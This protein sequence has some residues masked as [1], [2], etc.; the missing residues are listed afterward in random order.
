M[1]YQKIIDIIGGVAIGISSDAA[2]SHVDDSLTDRFLPGRT[3]DSSM[4]KSTRW[5]VH[6]E[7]RDTSVKRTS[8]GDV[9][10]EGSW[11]KNQHGDLPHLCGAFA[12]EQWEQAGL[13]TMHAVAVQKDGKTTL[14][15]GPSGCGK[16]SVALAA[17]QMGATVL[18]SNTSLLDINAKGIYLLAGTKTITVREKDREQW[19]L[20]E[21]ATGGWIHVNDMV[22]EVNGEVR[23]DAIILADATKPPLKKQV[24]FPDSFH[25]I[26]AQVG[27]PLHQHCV[28]NGGRGMF[29][30]RT[31]MENRQ[32]MVKNLAREMRVIPLWTMHGHS[33][34][35]AH[36]IG[37]L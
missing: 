3:G 24:P 13:W 27:D 37:E 5:I 35:I 31:H 10:I 22:S 19:Q 12:R 36:F 30:G 1:M 26:V 21:P 20:H 11:A 17:L 14:I 32:I 16:T 9:I 2:I 6:L 15:V 8:G 28:L 25:T 4:R 34:I 33:K 29:V 7:R 23:I 18:S